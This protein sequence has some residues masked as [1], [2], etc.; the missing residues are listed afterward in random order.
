MKP[1]IIYPKLNPKDHPELSELADLVGEF[2]KY[3]G[4]K[5][6]QGRMWCY[7]FVSNQPLSSVELARLLRISPPL[8]TQS[9]QVL[10]EYRVILEAEKGPNGVLRFMANPNVA[11]A[12][13]GVLAG[14]ENLLMNRIEKASHNLREAERKHVAGEIEIDEARIQQI[15]QWISLAR[16]ALSAGL[17]LLTQKDN[18]FSAP[19]RFRK[20]VIFKKA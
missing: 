5:A 3:W 10:L 12:I 6:V 19:E 9:A 8:V 16:M 4:F 2:I 7:L 11:E 13:G 18:P 15:L 14:R 20:N 17:S 1:K